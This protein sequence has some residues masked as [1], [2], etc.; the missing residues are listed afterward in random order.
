VSETDTNRLDQ[1]VTQK[2]SDVS[3]AFA[4]KLITDNKVKVN[5][6]I[7][8]KSGYRLRA[9]DKVKIDYDAESQR[10][11]PSIKLK[12]IYEDD[13]CVVIDKPAGILSH[14][15]GAF[16]PEATVASWLSSRTKGMEGNDRDGIVHRLDRLTS[17]VM[18]CAKTPEAQVWLQKQ[19]SQRKT[20]KTYIALIAGTLENDKA[21]IDMPIERNPKKPQTFRVGE[22]GKSSQTTYKVLKTIG[23]YSEVEL[24]P[25]TGR[26]HQL[27]VHLKHINHPIVGDTLY[28]GVKAKRLFLHAK[29]LEITLPNRQRTVFYSKLPKDFNDELKH[30]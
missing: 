26:T 17:G 16:N 28:G 7:E 6:V 14:S 9:K 3:R 1:Y 13:D 20:K 30:A 8:S 15:K 24:M 22:N 10:L 11:I 27:R 5:G 12:I 2:L 4:S 23:K 29:S 19:F 25:K 18:I 21:I